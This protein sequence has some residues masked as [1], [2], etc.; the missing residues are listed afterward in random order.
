MLSYPR[1]YQPLEAQPHPPDPGRCHRCHPPVLLPGVDRRQFCT[2]CHP[3]NGHT[4]SHRDRYQHAGYADRNHDSFANL[5]L[6]TDAHAH[7]YSHLYAYGY[8]E[9][10]AHLDSQPDPLAYALSYPDAH[11]QFYAYDHTVGHTIAFRY[12]FCYPDLLVGGM[13]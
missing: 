8:P 1:V 3:T 11:P 4:N 10:N 5:H 9:R 2:A 6:D 7:A 12:T 13:D